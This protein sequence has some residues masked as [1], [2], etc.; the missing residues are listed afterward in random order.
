MC[1]ANSCR[2][3]SVVGPRLGD[4]SLLFVLFLFRGFR[5]FG[6]LLSLR[7][8]LVFLTLLVAHGMVP[9]L[10]CLLHFGVDAGF[11]YAWLVGPPFVRPT[12]RLSRPVLVVGPE[13]PVRQFL[14]V[15]RYS[16]FIL[17]FDIRLGN[18]VAEV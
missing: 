15:C 2:I 18:P 11:A 5:L 14:C 4:A 13:P 8:G 17:Q 3:D 12:L 9:F 10:R 1:A 6:T 7:F 16:V